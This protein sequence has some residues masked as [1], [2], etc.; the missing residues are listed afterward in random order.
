MD[1]WAAVEAFALTL[2]GTEASTSYRQP[3]VKVDGKAFVSTGSEPGSF[4]VR[5]PH[6][7]KAVLM[8]T[9][10]ATFWQTPHYADW[11]GLLVRHDGPDPDRVRLVVVRAWWDRAKPATRRAWGERP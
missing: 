6:E 4:H 10:P 8:E 2:P 9:D 7:E 5:S 1:D 3:A 11:P